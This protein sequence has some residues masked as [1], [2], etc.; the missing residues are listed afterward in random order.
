MSRDRLLVC[1]GFKKGSSEFHIGDIYSCPWPPFCKRLRLHMGLVGTTK[2]LTKTQFS[3]AS[4]LRL[5]NPVLVFF[6]LHLPVPS[7][8]MNTHFIFCSCV[9]KVFIVLFC[10]TAALLCVFVSLSLSSFYSASW[11]KWKHT[12]AVPG[13]DRNGKCWHNAIQLKSTLA[14]NVFLKGNYNSNAT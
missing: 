9:S 8:D 7:A 13:T 2:Q 3:F 5:Q 10:S 14:N 4:S 6:L 1:R 12:V 11:W